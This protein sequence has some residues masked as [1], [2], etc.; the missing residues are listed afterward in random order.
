MIGS[1]QKA[2]GTSAALTA[3][4]LAVVRQVVFERAAEQISEKSRRSTEA[5]VATTEENRERSEAVT[6]VV[7]Q[8]EHRQEETKQQVGAANPEE[9]VRTKKASSSALGR[10]VDISV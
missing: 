2:P 6:V 8:N 5:V 4:N 10:A 7:E 1:A 3:L 9:P